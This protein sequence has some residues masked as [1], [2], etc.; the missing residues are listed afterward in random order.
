MTSGM[1]TGLVLAGGAARGAYEAGVLSYLREEFEPQFDVSELNGDI[2]VRA[3]VP[4]V[5]PEDL[6]LTLGDHRLIVAGARQLGA[7]E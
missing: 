6:H 5:R 4:G 1:K 2:I 7:D 3:D